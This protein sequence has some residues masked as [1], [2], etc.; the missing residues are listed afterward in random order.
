VEAYFL[1]GL[2]RPTINQGEFS[3][4]FSLDSVDMEAEEEGELEEQF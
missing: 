1:P 2:P 4:F 3:F